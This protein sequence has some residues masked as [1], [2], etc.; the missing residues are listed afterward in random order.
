MTKD[1]SLFT[2]EILDSEIVKSLSRTGQCHR[3]ILIERMEIKGFKPAVVRERITA[4]LKDRR[5]VWMARRDYL[6]HN[7]R[8]VD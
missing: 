5:I 1:V 3:E 8:R 4:L 7:S 2:T 6:G